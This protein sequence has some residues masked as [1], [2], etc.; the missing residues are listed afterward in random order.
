[1][2]LELYRQ[3]N[4]ADRRRLGE[5][6]TFKTAVDSGAGV[7]VRCEAYPPDHPTH[8]NRWMLELLDA[9]DR[10]VFY[11]VL[12]GFDAPVKFTSLFDST[13]DAA[14]RERAAGGEIEMT[15]LGDASGRPPQKVKVPEQ[16][17]DFLKLLRAERPVAAGQPVT[18][19]WEIHAF[20]TNTT[21]QD[22]PAPR[23]QLPAGE[24]GK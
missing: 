14:P 11:R 2:Q 5:V 8:A 3:L 19:W 21:N 9:R 12:D 1:M 6:F 13:G 23:F 7:I 18:A 16:Q 20:I 22:G 4:D 24:G 17:Y 10:S 15:L